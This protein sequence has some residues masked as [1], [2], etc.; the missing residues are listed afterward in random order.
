LS[1][2]PEVDSQRL[3]T[4]GHSLGAKEALYLAAL[5]ERVGVAASHEG[6]V[7]IR[8]SNWDAPWY[9]GRQVRRDSFCRD[10]HELLGLVAPRAFLLFGGDGFDGV[11]S[12]P[13]V[14]AAMPV[15][16]LYETPARLGLYNHHQGHKFTLEAEQRIYEWFEAYG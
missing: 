5:D 4:V 9:L 6:G 8:F 3:G 16:N 14:E 2:L 13:F 15:Y 10:H 7:G 11:Q 12:W 1:S